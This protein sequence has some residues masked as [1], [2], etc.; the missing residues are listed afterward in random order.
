MAN[1]SEKGLIARKV[2]MTRMTDT[3]GNV[4]PV[5]LLKVE[6][7]KVTKVLTEERDGYNAYQIG[8][9]LKSEKNLNKSD[10]TRLRKTGINEN[11]SNFREFRTST[12]VPHEVGATLGAALYDGVTSVD[13][14][15]ETKGRGFQGAIKPVRQIYSNFDPGFETY[16]DINVYHQDDRN[17]LDGYKVK[18]ESLYLN[19]QATTFKDRLTLL[20]G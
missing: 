3:N 12:P 14:S 19:W 8:F 20:A 4:I 9:F 18:N 16:P 2:G 13:V 1:H 17:A 5:T 15:G 7:Q 10:I 11:F 6:E